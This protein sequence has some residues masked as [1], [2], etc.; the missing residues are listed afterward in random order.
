VG[1]VGSG[2]ADGH[3]VVPGNDEGVLGPDEIGEDVPDLTPDPIP[4]HRSA[5]LPIER[6]AKPDVV[7]VRGREMGDLEPAMTNANGIGPEAQKGRTRPNRTDQAD[8]RALP[9]WRR[10]LTMARPARVD[11]RC[12]KPCF[13]ARLR[14]LG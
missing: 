13:F 2:I 7:G 1:H 8:S 9:R 3:E 10:A 5:H 6:E 14:T 11:M 12:R 4:T